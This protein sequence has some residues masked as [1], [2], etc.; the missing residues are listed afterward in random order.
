MQS[1]QICQQAWLTTVDDQ[2]R[3][4]WEEKQAFLA[5]ALSITSYISYPGTHLLQCCIVQ[6]GTL[7]ARMIV[8]CRFCLLNHASAMLLRLRCSVNGSFVCVTCLLF[9][10]WLISRLRHRAPMD[11][12]NGNLGPVCRQWRNSTCASQIQGSR[13][14]LCTR[15]A[16]L[17]PTSIT[18]PS[19][20]G[21]VVGC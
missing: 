16:T 12:G 8:A 19:Y 2:G 6:Y 11:N 1:T 10:Y 20:R 14:L 21:K 17:K 3:S 7:P 13:M 15:H 18:V 4:D 5:P 9:T